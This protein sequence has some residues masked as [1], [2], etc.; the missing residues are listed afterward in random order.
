MLYSGERIQTPMNTD[1]RRG[2]LDKLTEA[3]VGCAF[4]V[5]NALGMGFLEKVYENALAVELRRAGI[6]VQQQYHVRVT[7]EGTV[8]GDF[9]ADLLVEDSIRMFASNPGRRHHVAWTESGQWS[10]SI[11]AALRERR[12]HA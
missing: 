9:T 10:H 4:K 8:V 12:E 2:R 7:Y 5:S 11:L 3:I 6:K 1:E